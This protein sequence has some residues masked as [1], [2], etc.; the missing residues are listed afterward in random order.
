MDPK[1]SFHAIT[2]IYAS[3][4][5]SRLGSW[6]YVSLRSLGIKTATWNPVWSICWKY[7]FL[8]QSWRARLSTDALRAA[9][10][11]NICF[12]LQSW[13]ARLCTGAS[14]EAA[15]DNASFSIWTWWLRHP[16]DE[17]CWISKHIGREQILTIG[18]LT[19]TQCENFQAQA[20]FREYRCLLLTYAHYRISRTCIFQS[21]RRTESWQSKPM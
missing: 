11:E 1:Q 2:Q 9:R 14:C 8:L 16:G 15:V 6:T 10:V 20:M 18:L 12:C 19:L 13:R 4:T 3:V 7:V 21:S 5:K 17:Q